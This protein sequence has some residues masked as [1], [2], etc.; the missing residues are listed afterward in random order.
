M[1]VSVQLG[2]LPTQARGQAPGSYSCEGW[3]MPMLQP[4][5]YKRLLFPA[6]LA[7]SSPRQIAEALQCPLYSFLEGC[8]SCSQ[9]STAGL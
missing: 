3:L 7:G 5:H 9:T 8:P 6:T 4:Y 1:S 2:W